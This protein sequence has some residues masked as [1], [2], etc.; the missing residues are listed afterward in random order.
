MFHVFRYPC[1]SCES[2]GWSDNAIFEQL[3]NE[4]NEINDFVGSSDGKKIPE[5][6]FYFDDRLA[7]PI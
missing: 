7:S 2:R 1:Y 5:Y 4:I 6:F 3:V